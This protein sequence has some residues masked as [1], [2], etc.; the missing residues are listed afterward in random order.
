MIPRDCYLVE[1]DDARATGFDAQLLLFLGDGEAR[2][3][4]LHYEGRDT[5][6]TLAGVEIGEHDEEIRFHGV[7]DPHFAPVENV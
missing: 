7:G 1:V 4:L 2:G 5:F 6:V 3:V